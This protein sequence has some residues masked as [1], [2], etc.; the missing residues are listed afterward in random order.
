VETG[1][2]RKT[3]DKQKLKQDDLRLDQ[4]PRDCHAGESRHPSC[5]GPVLAARK[6]DSGLRRN[7]TRVLAPTKPNFILPQD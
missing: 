7:D 6:M 5:F 1:F 3:R 4:L 2:S